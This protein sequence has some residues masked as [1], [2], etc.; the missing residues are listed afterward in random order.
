MWHEW[1][2]IAARDTLS[3]SATPRGSDGYGT[4]FATHHAAWGESDA[5]DILSGIDVVVKRGVLMQSAS[6]SRVDRMAGS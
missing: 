1:Q 6:A 2:I 5:N 3:S 4:T